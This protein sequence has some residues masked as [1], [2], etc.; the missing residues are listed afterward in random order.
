MSPDECRLFA[1]LCLQKV[2]EVREALTGQA[3]DADEVEANNRLY[4]DRVAN[5][6][7][8]HVATYLASRSL[9]RESSVREWQLL[10]LHAPLGT[11]RLYIVPDDTPSLPV[12][13]TDPRG[14]CLHVIYT[15]VLIV[16]DIA[17]SITHAFD[18]LYQSTNVDLEVLQDDSQGTVV[19]YTT[20][21]APIYTYAL[22]DSKIPAMHLAVGLALSVVGIKVVF[23]PQERAVLAQALVLDELALLAVFDWLARCAPRLYDR[24]M[25]DALAHRIIQLSHRA[26]SFDVARLIAHDLRLYSAAALA[27][28]QDEM[29][30]N[31]RLDMLFKTK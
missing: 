5:A 6:M 1:R 30:L 31:Q 14:L 27:V 7:Y 11:G 20:T 23:P 3:D 24:T 29:T 10:R 2:W 8:L 25:D 19:Q 9:A 18:G 13:A 22:V 12:L 4:I 26:L 21:N 16:M 17:D 28:G 15:A